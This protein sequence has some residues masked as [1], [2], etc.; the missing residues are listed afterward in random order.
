MVRPAFPRARARVVRAASARCPSQLV[1]ARKAGAS[2]AA[3]ASAVASEMPARTAPARVPTLATPAISLPDDVRRRLKDLERDGLT[4][5]ERVK[6][7]LNLLH[8][9]LQTEIK[10]Q[11]SDLETKL[12][13]EELSEISPW[14]TEPTPS[15]EKQTAI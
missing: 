11:L 4:E 7:K 9:F 12:R 8:E 5:K 3:V 6:E 15:I 2:C 14:R 13:K 10:A 1:S